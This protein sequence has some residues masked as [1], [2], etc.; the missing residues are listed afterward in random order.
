MIRSACAVALALGLAAPAATPK[1]AR[2]PIPGIGV[3]G[4]TCAMFSRNGASAVVWRS[5][6]QWRVRLRQPRGATAVIPLPAPP[7]SPTEDGPRCRVAFSADSSALAVG[8]PF[9]PAPDFE[10]TRLAVF[11]IDAASGG[12]LH[13]FNVDASSGAPPPYAILGFLGRSHRLAIWSGGSALPRE[14]GVSYYE[15]ATLVA[16]FKPGEQRPRLRVF[17][18]KIAALGSPAERSDP[19]NNRLWYPQGCPMESVTLTGP[20]SSGPV[21]GEEK[22]G[23]ES[24]AC[25]GDGGEPLFTGS[26]T[27]VG[28]AGGDSGGEVFSVDLGERSRVVGSLELPRVRSNHWM[29]ALWLASLSPDA[30][31]AA[32]SRNIA[33]RWPDIGLNSNDIIVVGLRPLRMLAHIKPPRHHKHIVAMAAG[34]RDGKRVLLVCWDGDWMRYTIPLPSP[35]SRPPATPARA[36][37]PRPRSPAPP[38][39]R[40]SPAA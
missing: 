27:L 18:R 13:H 2:L 7:P 22:A 5:G 20:R 39:A 33:T 8:L 15:A 34:V 38:P 36:S 12:I 40:T 1:P 14:G 35:R 31:F 9:G 6:G 10:A 19:A 29:Q 32:V 24:L 3:S 16:T 4:L 26:D 28:V 23:Q 21:V 17:R 11:V 25:G 37:S 30:S